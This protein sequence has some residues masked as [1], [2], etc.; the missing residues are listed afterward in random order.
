MG[1]RFAL[2]Q[3]MCFL[4]IMAF[5]AQ[6]TLD[7]NV[8]MGKQYDRNLCW[9]WNMHKKLVRNHWIWDV[10]KAEKKGQVKVGPAEKKK[11]KKQVHFAEQDDEIA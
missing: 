1:E 9:K 2:K 11:A 3:K 6:C 4:R 10:I 5:K 8:N 7:S